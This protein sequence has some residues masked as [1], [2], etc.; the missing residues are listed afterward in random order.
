MVS[1]SQALFW[2]LLAQGTNYCGFLFEVTVVYF[3]ILQFLQSG[4]HFKTSYFAIYFTGLVVDMVTITTWFL[5]NVFGNFS[6]TAVAV[7]N[8]FLWY[9]YL[10]LGFWNTVLAFNRLTAL[11]I[12]T[13]YKKIWNPITV[14]IIITLNT[15]FPFL[16]NG[17]S[18][19][20]PY[21]R[22]FLY[23]PTCIDFLTANQY[24]ISISNFFQALCSFIFGIL[25]FVFLQSR[26]QNSVKPSNLDKS[27]LVQ[28]FFS[29]IFLISASA[30]QFYTVFTEFK[31]ENLTKVLGSA[32]D[33]VFGLYHYFGLVFLTVFRSVQS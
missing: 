32:T 5:E 2:S 26:L 1:D 23:S 7:S 29:S 9:S 3:L 8:F 21:C 19:S 6:E 11:M 14:T 18:F 20:N 12:P 28:S 10:H 13:K 22:L 33:L 17:Y 27:L 31:D 25:S 16:I 24:F 4:S 30:I 15:I